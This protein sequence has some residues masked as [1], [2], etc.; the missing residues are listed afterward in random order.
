MA[1]KGGYAGKVAVI[2]LTAGA[3]ETISS[4]PYQLSGGGHTMA[5]EIMFD[6]GMDF[7]KAAMDPSNIFVFAASGMAGTGVPS[8]SDRTICG[9]QGTQSFPKEWVTRSGF[10]GRFA[11]MMKAAGYDAIA[12][13][14]ASKTPVWINIVED[15]ITIESAADLWGLGTWATQQEIWQ[16]A[17]G[18]TG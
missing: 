14:G 6:L 7:T 18:T 10:G 11:P 15:K 12:V 17:H 16:R 5:M 4:E 9:F 1:L 2:D 13:K 3:T 8:A